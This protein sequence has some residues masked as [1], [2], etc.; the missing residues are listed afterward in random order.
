MPT[1]VDRLLVHCKQLVTMSGGAATGAR[2]RPTKDS[3]GLIDD[4]AVAIQDGRIVATG[5]TAE[6]QQAYSAETVDDCSGLVV[7][8]GFVDCHTHPV[9]G[10]TREGE[11][12]MRT[13]GA[14][15]MAIAQAG[16]GILSSVEAVRSSTREQLLGRTMSIFDA[17]LR[18]GTTTIEGKSGYG[19]DLES[20]RKLLEVLTEAR[21][22]HPIDVHRTFLG[23]HEVPKEHR[24]DPDRYVDIVVDEMLPAMEGLCESCDVFAEP[25]VFNLARSRR[26]LE[27]GLAHGLTLRVHADEIEPMGGAELAV[28]LGAR[29]ADHLLVVTESGIDALAGSETTAVMLPGTSF[30]LG[31]KSHAPARAL[32]DQGAKVALASDYNPGSCHTLSM[33]LVC[34]LACV[35]LHMKPEECWTAVTINAAESLELDAEI[36]TLHDGKKADLVCLDFPSADGIGYVFGG[37]PVVRT[38]KAG[39]EVYRRAAA[40]V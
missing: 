11:F 31:K 32:I 38:L 3:L 20:E 6:I 35:L 2:R 27:A 21:D 14:D 17:F 8:P 25:K 4:G 7:A 23:A 15:Y 24:A 39:R 40:R 28:E 34:T 30:F 36:G 37:D 33:P 29:S 19:L 5:T 16:G 13:Q 18:H 10:A 12:H 22:Q 1:P 9:F 26:V